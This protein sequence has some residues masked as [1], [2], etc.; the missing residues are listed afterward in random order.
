MAEPVTYTRPALAV[1]ETRDAL[2]AQSRSALE[3]LANALSPLEQLGGAGDIRAQKERLERALDGDELVGDLTGPRREEAIAKLCSV[4]LV[5]KTLA[6][7]MMLSL[8]PGIHLDYEARMADGRRELAPADENPSLAVALDDVE[9]AIH[10]D[11]EKARRLARDP[12]HAA[13][14]AAAAAADPAGGAA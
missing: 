10:E 4:E 14:P 11:T 5:P 13:A 7:G 12:P 3:V 1:T 8:R 9:R 2:L 6:R